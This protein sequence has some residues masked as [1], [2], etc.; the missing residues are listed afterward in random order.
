MY[1]HPVAWAVLLLV[2]NNLPPASGL[3]AGALTGLILL[4]ALD[5]PVEDVVVLIPFADEQVAEE[6]AQVGVV[7]LVVETQSASVVQEDTELVREAPTE[8]VSRGSHLLLHDAIVFLLLRGSLEALPGERSTKEVHEN[9]SQ[10]LQII[11]TSLLDTQVSIDRGVTSGTSEVLVLSVGDVEVCLG[12]P[13]LLSK[14][15]IDDVDLV[16][17]L[18]NSHEEV[19]R[20]D[21]TVDEVAGMDVFDAGNLRISGVSIKCRKR[22][23]WKHS[24]ADLQATK[25]SSD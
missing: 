7:G 20:L 21:V 9:V 22:Y 6:F 18:A 3:G 23:R 8:E 2:L 17:A 4:G 11:A 15:E 14:A 5:T 1:L 13:V 19:V 12:V 10:G 16:A 24:P 25:R